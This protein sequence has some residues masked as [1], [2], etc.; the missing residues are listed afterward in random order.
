MGYKEAYLFVFNQLSEI[1]EKCKG[2]QFEAEE[3]VIGSNA[4]ITWFEGI[5]P[6][7][8]PK[9]KFRDTPD[10]PFIVKRDDDDY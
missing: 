4:E 6:E 2:I 3:K 9:V 5:N 8:E 7:D 1:I 10:E